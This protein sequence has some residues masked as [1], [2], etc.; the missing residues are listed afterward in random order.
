MGT[1]INLFDRM[2][3]EGFYKVVGF[4]ASIAGLIGF[5]WACRA[6]IKPKLRRFLERM[7]IVKPSPDLEK[8]LVLEKVKDDPKS[9]LNVGSRLIGDNSADTSLALDLIRIGLL[10]VERARRDSHV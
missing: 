5:W 6:K 10:S 9:A 8:Q 3:V 1:G 4:L 7:R 2:T